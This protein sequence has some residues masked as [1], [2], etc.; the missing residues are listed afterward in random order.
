METALT[1]RTPPSAESSWR[2]SE[3]I[4]RRGRIRHSR[5]LAESAA[6]EAPFAAGFRSCQAAIERASLADRPPGLATR[7]R[8][9]RPRLGTRS[10]GPRGF[11]RWAARAFLGAAL[12][13]ALGCGQ[14]QDG[15]WIRQLDEGSP[16]AC[17]RA[18][19]ALAELRSA[20]AVGPLARAAD[21]AIVEATK[22][23][24][25]SGSI[26][27]NED[28]EVADACYEAIV[29]IGQ[30]AALPELLRLMVEAD[31]NGDSEGFR[32]TRWALEET[33]RDDFPA[34]WEWPECVGSSPYRLFSGL[35]MLRR[36]PRWDPVTRER[37][38]GAYESLLRSVAVAAEVEHGVRSSRK[39][40]AGCVGSLLGIGRRLGYQEGISDPCARPHG[41]KAPR[42]A[43]TTP[44][45]GEN[46]TEG[47]DPV[48]V[49]LDGE[50]LVVAGFGYDEWFRD[51]YVVVA[52]ALDGSILWFIWDEVRPIIY[53][54]YNRAT[55]V[56]IDP[57][58]NV[59]IT[60]KSWRSDSGVTYATEKYAPD[61]RLLWTALSGDEPGL[62]DR[63]KLAVDS[64]GALYVSGS[65]ESAD[66][67]HRKPEWYL[68]I[69]YSP[70]GKE[71]WRAHFA[72]AG[73]EVSEA[74]T[75][76]VAKDGGVY[77]SGSSWRRG[78]TGMDICTVKYSPDGTELWS[79][80]YDGPGRGP[81]VPSA[82][83]VDGAGAVYV[84]GSSWGGAT[85][86]DSVVIKYSPEGNE[87]WVAR[88]D[89]PANGW[90][91]ASAIGLDAAGG[92]S[93]AGYSFGGDTGDDYL[94]IRY[95]PEGRELWVA[96]YD[97]PGSAEDE[98]GYVA[99]DGE[100]GVYVGG[101]SS[102]AEVGA[103]Y[104]VVKY[105]PGGQELWAAPYRCWTLPGVE[106]GQVHY[107][108]LAGM[109]VD[110]RGGVYLVGSR[111]ADA[112]PGCIVVVKF[113]EAE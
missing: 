30:E 1:N 32:A 73:A 41:A 75:V 40:S 21:K 6:R 70:D 98:A 72:P 65:S 101:R 91:A 99:V 95:S 69:K 76:A 39:R 84:A 20:R 78:G 2:S 113:A 85:D 105:S 13:A 77:V 57:D 51:G 71:L 107:D 50:K 17:M 25:E 44:P 87:I 89:G 58:G 109:A 103:E 4:S 14:A 43:W 56:A 35:D 19:R 93:I 62:S 80:M 67:S 66:V 63:V 53:E 111:R 59:C 28:V 52:Y 34:P 37:A 12:L 94:T 61:G 7:A 100:G 96:R 86:F 29:A 64:T 47:G 26:L 33:I 46:L 55:A 108:A 102:I 5:P 31:A 83:A 81:D 42:L 68:T 104:C 10:G 22:T 36:D 97:G 16:D 15:Y 45:C 79:V 110:G 24:M 11:A 90:D 74:R 48:A 92:V 106:A 3:G 38:N 9:G 8:L 88:Y 49:A 112:P 82:I 60:G 27:F 23:S 54:G 18:A